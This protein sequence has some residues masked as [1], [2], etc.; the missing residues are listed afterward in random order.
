MILVI[1]TSLL[2]VG[3]TSVYLNYKSTVDTLNETMQETAVIAAQRVEKELM[4]YKNV[5]IE[6]GMVARLS[7]PAT[8]VEEKK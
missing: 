5:A 7:N 3:I 4:G 2:T 6:T 8:T 1:M